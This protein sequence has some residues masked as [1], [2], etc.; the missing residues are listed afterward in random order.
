MFGQN[1]VLSSSTCQASDSD[2]DWRAKERLSEGYG[3]NAMGINYRRSIFSDEMTSLHGSV[4][5]SFAGLGG[6]FLMGDLGDDR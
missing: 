5:G 3:E 4:R 1:R 2:C 6:P